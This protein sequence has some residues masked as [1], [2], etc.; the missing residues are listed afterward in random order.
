MDAELNPA[1]ATV[2]RFTARVANEAER[3]HCVWT[4]LGMVGLEGDK[5][6]VKHFEA[7]KRKEKNRAKRQCQQ[8]LSLP[9]AQRDDELRARLPHQQLKDRSASSAVCF[10]FRVTQAE[11]EAP[12][13]SRVEQAMERIQRECSAAAAP[14]HPP[15]PAAPSPPAPVAADAA[16]VPAHAPRS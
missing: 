4:T 15:A 9:A 7:L 2:I 16:P 12:G 10:V 11:W 13:T 5:E 6:A 3:A 14:S 1:A 8:Q